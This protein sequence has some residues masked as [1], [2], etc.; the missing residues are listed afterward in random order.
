MEKR[1][2][3]RG[4]VR[5]PPLDE[6]VTARLDEQQERIATELDTDVVTLIAPLERGVDRVLRRAIEVNVE[7]GKREKVSII[8]STPGGVVEVLERMLATVRKEYGHLTVIVPDAAMSAGGRGAL[9]AAPATGGLPSAAR[10]RNRTVWD[11]RQAAVPIGDA[12][13]TGVGWRSI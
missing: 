2:S 3:K 4:R 6:V 13:L 10:R 5:I 1:R 11:W 8:L 7:E 9:A 12:P